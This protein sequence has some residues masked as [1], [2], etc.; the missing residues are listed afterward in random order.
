MNKNKNLNKIAKKYI[1][2]INGELSD[3]IIMNSSKV[4]YPFG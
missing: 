2:L 4:G 3:V 1:E